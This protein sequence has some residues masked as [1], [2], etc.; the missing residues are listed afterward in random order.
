MDPP[1]SW[2][3]P[4]KREQQDGDLEQMPSFSQLLPEEKKEIERGQV[5]QDMVCDMES[6]IPLSRM[7]SLPQEI[8][9]QYTSLILSLMIRI[10][11]F[12]CPTRTNRVPL[13]NIVP[14]RSRDLC[15]P[16]PAQSQ[17]ACSLSKATALRVPPLKMSIVFHHPQRYCWT[18]DHRRFTSPQVEIRPRG[19]AQS[20]RGVSPTYT[21]QYKFDIY[22][23]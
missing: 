6:S 22:N 18:L 15:I 7:G 3:S 14:D 4:I 10:E 16:R 5:E 1:G 19:Q 20:I 17:L 23:H 12:C 2:P 11:R 9:E 13:Q 8:I 21:D